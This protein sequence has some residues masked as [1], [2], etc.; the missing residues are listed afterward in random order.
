MT[1]E[2]D[3]DEISLREKSE[4]EGVAEQLFDD[5]TKDGKS[6]I[7]L[8]TNLHDE[9]I[10]LCLVNDAIFKLIEMPELSPTA[11]FKRLVSSRDGWKTNKFVETATGV[12]DQRESGLNKLGSLFNRREN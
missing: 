8:K 4:L 1:L 11:Q 10:G 7:D 6:S 9:E 3:L 5:S 2:K 12:K